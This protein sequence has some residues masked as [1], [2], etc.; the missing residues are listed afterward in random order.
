MDPVAPG[1]AYIAEDAVNSGAG[2]GGR[3]CARCKLSA[4]GRKAGSNDNNVKVAS[5]GEGPASARR[6]NFET[7]Y[8]GARG[9]GSKELEEHL[10]DYRDLVPRSRPFRPFK[11]RKPNGRGGDTKVRFTP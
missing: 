2:P 7:E 4:L 9:P 1:S 11:K 8:S 6:T 3:R 10:E 5:V